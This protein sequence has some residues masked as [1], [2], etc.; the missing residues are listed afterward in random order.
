VDRPVLPLAAPRAERGDAAR[1]RLHLL[2]TARE[3]L[4]ELGADKLTMDALAERA[5]LGKGTVFRRFGTRAGIF[6]ALL[7]DDERAFQEQVLSG[8]PPLGPGAPPVDRL[9]AYGRA[10]IGFLID[11]RE[12]ARAALDGRQPVPAGTETPLSRMHIRALL[13]QLD[14]GLAD[15]DVLAIQLTAALDGPLLLYLSA[16]DLTEAAAAPR[17]AD[18]ITNGWQDLVE[19]VCRPLSSEPGQQVLP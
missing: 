3:M 15:V 1:N 14:I 17:T 19:R 5:S 9:I 11:H 12:I 10:R 8:P 18:R 13:R 16:S 4:A 6:Q 2:A 7:D